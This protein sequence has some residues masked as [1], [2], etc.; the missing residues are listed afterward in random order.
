MLDVALTTIVVAA[1]ETLAFGLLPLS[2]LEGAALFEWSKAV[3]AAFAVLGAFAFV[4]VLLHPAS[5]AGEFAGRIGYLLVLLGIYFAV[6][7]SFWAWFR[8]TMTEHSNE[9]NDKDGHDN[10]QQAART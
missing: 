5:G 2:F 8:F 3:W 6:A 7:L 10:T 9:G 4:H 1:A